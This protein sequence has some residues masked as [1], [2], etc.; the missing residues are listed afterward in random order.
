MKNPNMTGI[1]DKILVIDDEARMCDSLYE[2]LTGGGYNVIVTQSSV[3]ALQMI[4]KD[5]FDLIVTDIKM[6]DVSGLDILKKARQKDPETVVILMTGF[7]SLE[8][9]LEAIKSG[10]FEY[11]MKPVE[12][13]QLEVSV[14]RGLEIREANL[15]RK[16]LLVELKTANE[17]LKIRLN[18]I[19]A[20]YEASRSLM[21][22]SDLKELLHKIITLAAGVTEAGIGSLMLIDS[23]GRHLTIEASIGLDPKIADSVELPIGS[24]IAGFVAESGEPLVVE[25]VEED[26]RF[27][28]INKERYSSSSLLCVPLEA[29]GR[30]LGVIN[31]A[32]KKGG[33]V[34]TE[35]DLKLLTTFASQA[36]VAIDDARHFED[37]MRKLKEF[38]ILLELSRELSA[39]G[40]V[41]AMRQAVFKNMQ[42][43][44]SI[45]YAL[46]F[47]WQAGRNSLRLIGAVGTEIPLT[48][49][50]SIDVN[51]LGQDDAI[52]SQLDLEDVDLEN[53]EV[54]SRVIR[55]KITE[56]SIYPRPGRNFTAVP[57]FQ[58]G[59][60]KHVFCIDSTGSDRYT[61]GDI[62]LA[63]LVISQASGLYE[64]E[65]A[66]LNATRLLTMGNMISEISHDLRR[67]LT[68]I[69]GWI[70]ILREKF[71]TV[72]E[73]TNFYR[74]A[75]EEI[76]RLNEL[77]KEL[78][79]FS[80]PQKYDMEMRDIRV[81]IHRAVE[82]VGPELRKKSIS[83]CESFGEAEYA[84]PVN[85]N[86][87]LEVFLNLFLNSLD[88]MDE[89]G[90]LKITGKIAKPSFRD[91]S[92]LAIIV[93]DNGCG[94]KKE[95]LSKIFDRYY[96]SK[97]S[98]TGL[99]LTVVERIMTAHGGLCEVHSTPDQGTDF[100][101][102]F[103]L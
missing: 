56:Y 63:R 61:E 44:I 13:S 55:E 15:A 97:E 78:V 4:E 12:F 90:E 70:Q 76:H 39:V 29:S 58:E 60:L 3:E 77:V 53:I 84:I 42:K 73:D 71:P 95:N 89:K 82:L 22:A 7:A 91:T 41:A 26:S 65:K 40:S 99:G 66:L 102:Y 24:S 88:A 23:S 20:L 8:S 75:E 43:L 51:Q 47:E 62:S 87:I 16:K 36:A 21:A 85:K 103:P 50:G 49:S 10:A 69:K 32:S 101:L 59:V 48:D 1:S 6:P 96:T 80:K 2:L 14:K 28:R 30:T 86:Q 25:N 27:K 46:W 33:L 35:H 67:P 94:I 57:A 18:E 93:S 9:S 5:S 34:F 83:I 45:D 52:V 72:A 31:M 19:N 54:F 79:D 37:N 100:A 38:S 74:M 64:R 17:N 98:G 92:Y 81:I 11:L 68:N